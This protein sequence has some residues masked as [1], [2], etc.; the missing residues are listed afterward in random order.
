MPYLHWETSRNRERFAE[1]IDHIVG[2]H[3]DSIAEAEIQEKKKRQQARKFLHNGLEASNNGQSHKKPWI[4]RKVNFANPFV[5]NVAKPGTEKKPEPSPVAMRQIFT[6]SSLAQ[7]LGFPNSPVK[8]DK[9]GRL[10]IVHE[11]EKGER[12]GSPLG[13]YLIDAARMF[14]AIANYRD[15]RLLEKFL[16]HDPPMHPRRTLHQAYYWM[17]DT[18]RSSDTD[19]VVYRATTAKGAEFHKYDPKERTW[20]KHE[21]LKIHESC[22]DCSEK[23]K[24]VSRVVMVD[25]LWMWILDANTVITCFPKRY[26]V[27]KHDAS[28]V[29]KMVQTR[30]GDKRQPQVRSVFDLAL[31]I[32]EEC[33]ITFFDRTKTSEQPQVLH[34][35]SN[36]IRSVVSQTCFHNGMTLLQ[37][38]ILTLNVYYSSTGRLLPLE[39]CG[40]GLR[41]RATYTDLAATLQ[42]CSC[43][44]RYL[45][46]SYK[47]A[48]RRRSK[49][50]LRS[51]ES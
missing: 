27:S 45:I 49:T 42:T 24:K 12:R 1:Q 23:I 25:Q 5:K 35:F 51:W 39:A 30:L 41:K 40:V 16:I 32:F 15:K 47:V 4:S 22:V 11:N 36:A 17:L 38:V 20:P 34:D 14:E 10:Q 13:Q 26:G 28:G 18:T 33:S 21:D 3:H 19:Q 29:H 2:K 44:C 37:Q 8:A 50:S 43:V 6:L 7:R 48:W 46:S 31:I 9:F